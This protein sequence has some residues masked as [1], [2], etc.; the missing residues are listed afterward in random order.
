MHGNMNVKSRRF[1]NAFAFTIQQ[2]KKQTARSL[3]KRKYEPS[4]RQELFTRRQNLH[5]MGFELSATECENISDRTTA[6]CFITGC[7]AFPF[8]L[9][10]RIYLLQSCASDKTSYFASQILRLE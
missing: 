5:T 7:T 1:D 2:S 9:A 3:R 4:K 10:V 8:L 6:L